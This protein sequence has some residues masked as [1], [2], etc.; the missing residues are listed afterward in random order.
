[1][2]V[3]LPGFRRWRLPAVVMVLALCRT[4]LPL[5][6][7]GLAAPDPAHASAGRHQDQPLRPG[8]AEI[9]SIHFEGNATLSSAEL[10]QQL[11][12]RETP[13]FFNKFLYKSISEKLGRKDEFFN[14]I[15]VGADIGRLKKY[16]ENRGFFNAAVDTLLAFAPDGAEVDITFRIKEGYRSLI[17]SLVYRGIPDA[18][19]TIWHDIQAGPRIAPGDPF[20]SLLLEDEVKRVLGIFADNGFP[21]AAF[22]RDSSEAQY[23]AS[24]PNFRVALSFRAGKRYRFGPVSVEQ[25]VDSLRGVER[26]TDITDDIVDRQLDYGPGDFYSQELRRSSERNLNRLGVFDLRRIDVTVP[27]TADTAITIPSHIVIRPKDK[28]ELAPELIISNE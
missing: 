22:I 9:G 20:N 28:H 12:T 4:P 2:P 15:L 8:Q 19:E 18:P 16:Y 11:A 1:M 10:R 17:D 21:N 6:G 14:P 24:A 3:F 27:P 13:G 5:G 26:R 25:E 23:R 7:L